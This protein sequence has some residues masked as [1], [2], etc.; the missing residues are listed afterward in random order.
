MLSQLENCEFRLP[1]LELDKRHEL[2]PGSGNV[3][4]VANQS[5]IGLAKTS[6]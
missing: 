2:S 3:Q 5:V 4:S 1:Q 6:S